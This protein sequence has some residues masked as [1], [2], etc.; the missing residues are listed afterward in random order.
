MVPAKELYD[1]SLQN[2]T[3]QHNLDN[4]KRINTALAYIEKELQIYAEKG[5]ATVNVEVDILG[6]G[7]AIKEILEDN[8]YEVSLSGSTI[9]GM[10]KAVLTIRFKG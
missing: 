5:I 2:K 1:K 7:N 10:R 6:I 8:G 4:N 9:D 3:S